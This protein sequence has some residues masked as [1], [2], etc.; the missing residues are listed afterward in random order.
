M[1]GSVTYVED[2]AALREFLSWEGPP[3]RDFTRRMNTL[4]YRQ[5]QAAPRDTGHMAG[6]ISARRMTSDTGRYLEAACGVNP[7]THGQTG[8][9]NYVASGTRPHIIQPRRARALRFIVAGRTVFTQ[10]VHHPGT[11]PNDFLTQHLNEFV[12]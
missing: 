6:R 7:G 5:Q 9:A 10:R 12:R 4:A 3:G 1:A 11:R 8:Y 2:A